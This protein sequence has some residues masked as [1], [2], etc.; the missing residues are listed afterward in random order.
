[1]YCERYQLISKGRLK[2]AVDKKQFIES[3]KIKLDIDLSKAQSLIQGKAK[4]I[5][6]DL[7][8]HELKKYYKAFET[9]GL[10]IT[11]QLIMDDAAF[12]SA[13]VDTSETESFLVD[14][15]SNKIDTTFFIRHLSKIKPTVFAGKS[16]IDIACKDNRKEY[17][18]NNNS[19]TIGTLALLAAV[20][21]ASLE[22][23]SYIVKLLT[24]NYG[25][26]LLST[27]T[28]LL[29]LIGGLVFLP[30][31]LSP[32]GRMELSS[33]DKNCYTLNEDSGVNLISKKFR[34]SINAV[35][36]CLIVR[37]RFNRYS[38]RCVSNT[39]KI[40]YYILKNELP[41]SELAGESAKDVSMDLA[42]FGLMEYLDYWQQFKKI[43]NF[44]KTS[45]RS[46][47]DETLE[48]M[49]Q[50]AYVYNGNNELIAKL[51][52]SSQL[53]INFTKTKLNEEEEVKVL[54]LAL[55]SIGVK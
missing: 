47:V 54:F 34:L 51:Y 53:A 12:N 41:A 45:T 21:F 46:G 20:V 15:S 50:Y 52:L 28:S 5:K 2:P 26:S 35:Q 14:E 32:L 18:L 37:S 44:F 9:S 39:G 36:N 17:V 4:I 29:V 22:L 40:E 25:F 1:M 30:V 55:S 8:L 31:L 10:D 16:K 11:A 6:K 49:D 24:L 13:L 27:I 48:N 23:E 43:F 38:A 19:L 3:L 7:S 42:D 33:K